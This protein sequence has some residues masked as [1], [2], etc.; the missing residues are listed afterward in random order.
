MFG[1]D[2]NLKFIKNEGYAVL[3]E[4][5][6]SVMKAFS[7]NIR[8][9]LAIGGSHLFEEQCELLIRLGIKDIIVSFD[10]DKSFTGVINSVKGLKN[11]YPELKFRIH[12][13]LESPAVS[14]KSSIFDMESWTKSEIENHILNYSF[15]I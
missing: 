1:I 13:V 10:S 8:N 11:K 4:A 9:V 15:E 5:E 7:K 14:E 6:K 12:K 2:K 3:V